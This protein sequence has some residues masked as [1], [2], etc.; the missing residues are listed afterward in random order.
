M[1]SGTTILA[2]VDSDL[3]D[4][5]QIMTPGQVTDSYLLALAVKNRVSWRPSIVGYR[6]GP[7]AGRSWPARYQRGR[8]KGQTVGG[9]HD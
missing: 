3:V 5:D 9:N 8:V 7:S 6:P 2:W 1:F 4:V